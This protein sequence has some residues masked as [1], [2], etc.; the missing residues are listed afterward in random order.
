MHPLSLSKRLKQVADYI[1]GYSHQPI[2]LAD[3]GTDHAYLPAYL[4]EGQLAQWALAGDVALG[5]LQSARDNLAAWGLEDRVQT[6]LGDG[7]EVIQ[8]ADQVNAIAIAGM[9]GGLIRDILACGQAVISRDC[10]LVLQA[11]VGAHILREWLFDQG[12]EILDECIVLEKGHLYDVLAA[13]Q[14]PQP[15]DYSLRDT[16]LGPIN[17]SRLADKHNQAKWQRMLAQAREIQGGIRQG[18]APDPVRLEGLKQVIEI[19]ESVVL[20]TNDSDKLQ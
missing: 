5:P 16:L 11:N 12:Y 20:P 15:L 6:R 17:G 1:I 13:R 3:I 2:R 14:A 7:L 19:L 4:V 8:E 9:G 18:Q 10:L